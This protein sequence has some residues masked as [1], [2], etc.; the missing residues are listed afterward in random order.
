[1]YLSVGIYCDIYYD[2]FV[3]VVDGPNHG[4]DQ[5][6][7]SGIRILDLTRYL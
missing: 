6:P 3:V 7:L 4:N 1:M 2:C 5:G